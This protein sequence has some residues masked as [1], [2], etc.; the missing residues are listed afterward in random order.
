[1]KSIFIQIR[2]VGV[3][4]KFYLIGS[5]ITGVLWFLVELSFI[6]V[7]QVFLVAID[8]MSLSQISNKLPVPE[9]K[10]GAILLLIAFGTTRAIVYGLK[11]YFASRAQV[12]FLCEKRK[13]VAEIALSAKVVNMEKSLSVF[14]EFSNQAGIAVYNLTLLMSI[15][16]SA[17]LYLFIGLYMAPIE[18]LIGILL[19]SLMVL[20]FK[21]I[22]QIIE[23]IGQELSFEWV[24]INK[25]LINGIKNNFFLKVYAL[26]GSEI[27]FTKNS[28]AKYE[29]DFEKYSISSAILNSLPMFIGVIVLSLITFLS[30]S[31]IKTEPVQLI[32]FFYIF[33]RLAQ[34]GS[35]ISSVYSQIKINREGFNNLINYLEGAGKSV[36]LKE[37][38][39]V[40]HISEIE[41]IDVCFSYHEKQILNSVSMSLSKGSFLLIK[42]K[43]GTGKSTLVEM[44]LGILEPTSGMVLINKK[45]SRDYD[46][47]WGDLLGYVGPD[48]FLINGSILENLS[49]GSMC[50]RDIDVM[51]DV[52]EGVGLLEIIGKA[53]LKNENEFKNVQDLSTGQKQRISI[54]RALL[55]KPKLLVLDE[56]FANLDIVSEAKIMN[57]IRTTYPELIIIAVSHR[58]EMDSVATKRIELG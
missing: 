46:I 57:F 11:L 28:L 22:N 30:I 25:R 32:A 24:K 4:S 10:G 37:K 36:R 19:M 16:F 21:K 50:G 2:N 27:L 35:E 23:I 33:I 40:D 12:A 1:M 44:I 53:N 43:S 7:I 8:I 39:E 6:Y 5:I 54:A 55:R 56:A 15:L 9:T 41:L 48:P 45:A 58:G 38:Y 51:V 14:T 20:P 13:E 17:A 47:A 34:S 18:M 42:G 49:Y 3:K 52:L 29:E 26:I 31:H